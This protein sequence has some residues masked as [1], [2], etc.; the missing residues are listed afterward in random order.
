MKDIRTE[1]IIFDELTEEEFEAMADQIIE[2][3]DIDYRHIQTSAFAQLGLKKK[4]HFSRKGVIIGLVA[5][6]VVLSSIGVGVAASGSFQKAFGGFIAG[7]AP[8]GVSSGSHLTITSDQ[9]DVQFLGIYGNDVTACA[10]F[11]LKKKDG[12]DF[13][14]NFEQVTLDYDGNFYETM[15]DFYPDEY[16]SPDFHSDDPS[17][18]SVWLTSRSVT[19]NETNEDFFYGYVTYQM[20][21]NGT[22][23]AFV[24]SNNSIGSLKGKTMHIRDRQINAYQRVE[25]VYEPARCRADKKALCSDV[26]A[27]LGEQHPE[28]WKV[29][30]KVWE[31]PTLAETIS[32]E[33]LTLENDFLRL[34][35]QAYAPLLKD[36]QVLMMNNI[37]NGWSICEKTPL[38]LD[39]DI[40]VGVE[41]HTTTRQFDIDTAKELVYTPHPETAI[42][43]YA[44][45]EPSDY[46]HDPVSF[47]L[48]SLE[49]D[50]LT[51]SFKARSQSYSETQS[52]L[53][54]S[55]Y[56]SVTVEMKD[57]TRYRSLGIPNMENL[58]GT[59]SSVSVHHYWLMTEGDDTQLAGIDPQD[60]A[61]IY[62]GDTKLFG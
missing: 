16:T 27:Q 19:G 24:L 61:A 8:D 11:T 55:L 23:R 35:R 52:L 40:A 62:L 42:S 15:P 28:M 3:N 20:E 26:I 30:V 5:A 50:A 37:Y 21:D 48:E 18:R 17:R 13:V 34:I 59:D 41:Y 49:A 47:T 60:I 54:R 6:A 1:T 7:D 38:V 33:E 10:S 36:N 45:Y 31:N 46:M 58:G 44:D 29:F 39:Y 25:T 2:Q 22:I 14:Q 9:N 57:G 53:Q 51:I 4:K 43:N 12:T 56:D 32:D